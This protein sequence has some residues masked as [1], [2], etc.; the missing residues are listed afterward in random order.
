MVFWTHSKL[1]I[2]FSGKRNGLFWQ[3]T[4]TSFRKNIQSFA[5]MDIS[6]RYILSN[7][8]NGENHFYYSFDDTTELPKPGLIWNLDQFKLMKQNIFKRGFL[9]NECYNLPR[10]YRKALFLP[11]QRIFSP[12]P[13]FMLTNGIVTLCTNSRFCQTITQWFDKWSYCFCEKE[14]SV[15]SLCVLSNCS[16]SKIEQKI[17]RCSTYISK[18]CQK[19]SR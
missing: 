2:I 19:L 15:P 11:H 18:V 7:K 14:L 3:K 4:R 12:Q 6:L 16:L 17:W 8:R 5:K 9:E 13:P 10:Q 1:S